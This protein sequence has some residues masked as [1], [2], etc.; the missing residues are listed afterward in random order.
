MSNN[1]KNANDVMQEKAERV[2]DGV[3]YWASFYLCNPHRFVK[4]YLNIN[5]KLFQKTMLLKKCRDYLF[6]FFFIL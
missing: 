6:H 5:L 2:L 1:V 3:A 4:D